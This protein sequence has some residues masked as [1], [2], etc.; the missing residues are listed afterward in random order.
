MV[1]NLCAYGPSICILSYKLIA[2]LS[3]YPV[4]FFFIEC[5]DF[6]NRAT[7]LLALQWRFIRSHPKSGL[8][9]HEFF[10]VQKMWDKTCSVGWYR[11]VK[12]SKGFP[13]SSPADLDF[14][15]LY[16]CLTFLDSAV[17]VAKCPI[18]KCW[19]YYMQRWYTCMRCVRKWI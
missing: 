1:V 10:S 15:R 16:Q 12:Q 7:H 3:I 11:R 6:R 9:P 8:G 19:F 18:V 4:F 13:R 2:L 14:R 5:V 17:A